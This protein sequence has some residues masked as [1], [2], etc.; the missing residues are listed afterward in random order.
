MTTTE[1]TLN[2]IAEYRTKTAELIAALELAQAAQ[3]TAEDAVFNSRLSVGR[4]F[5]T[6]LR[7]NEIEAHIR[8]IRK[9]HVDKKTELVVSVEATHSLADILIAEL[10]RLSVGRD[11]TTTLRDSPAP[12][13]EAPVVVKEVIVEEVPAE[14]VI[15][16]AVVADEVPTDEVVS[17]TSVK[18]VRKAG[19]PRSV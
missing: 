4:D 17:D 14:E 11:F 2:V 16:D 19:R 1:K 9:T 3:A 12:V 10:S 6:T 8:S 5:T 7:D 18:P 13:V 15:A